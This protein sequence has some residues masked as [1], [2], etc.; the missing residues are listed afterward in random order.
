MARSSTK[1][2]RSIALMRPSIPAGASRDRCLP[3]PWFEG[4]GNH[5]DVLVDRFVELLV[6]KMGRRHIPEIN[7]FVPCLVGGIGIGAAMQ[8]SIGARAHRHRCQSIGLR[9]STNNTSDEGRTNK[10]KS[11][12]FDQVHGRSGQREWLKG[13]EPPMH[14]PSAHS[15]APSMTLLRLWRD[16]AHSPPQSEAAVRQPL[17]HHAL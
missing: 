17:T 11:A 1:G 12:S 15:P 2:Q 13:G 4:M 7:G 16:F 3:H 8:S 14:S 9:G 6:A 10:G 5:S